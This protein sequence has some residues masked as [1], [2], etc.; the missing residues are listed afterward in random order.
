VKIEKNQGLS[1][2]RRECQNSASHGAIAVFILKS[3]VHG[4]MVPWLND[5]IEWYCSHRNPPKFRAVQIRGQSKEP[6]RKSGLPTPPVKR[7]ICSQ[8]RL[9]SHFLRPAAISA[10]PIRQVHE[11]SLPAADDTLERG[12]VPS[13]YLIYSSLILAG[14]HATPSE[15][16]PTYAR[17]GCISFR[18]M[19]LVKNATGHPAAMSHRVRPTTRIEVD[20]MNM[21]QF[22]PVFLFLSVA[23]IA[24]FS[25]IAVAVWSQERRR[26]REAYYRS[27]TL[28]KLADTQGAGSSSA[29]D[30]LREEEKNAVRRRRE[31]QKL[32]G[33]TTVAVGIA[34]MVFI[35]S[36]DRGNPAY[37][38]GLIPLFIGAALLVYVYFLGPNQ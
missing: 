22:L 1:I 36:V 12:G 31:G 9:L 21:N 35:R 10:E 19:R 8:K 5:L 20:D 11:G 4:P 28:K 14:A 23:S 38:V 15:V 13:K 6:S 32:G 17:D 25:F 30:F 34:L 2:L 26:E 7:A 16:R 37:L 29:I 18:G 24:L 27:E 33:L 3:S